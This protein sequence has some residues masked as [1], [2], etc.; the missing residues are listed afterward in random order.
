M[1]AA[2]KL[3]DTSLIITHELFYGASQALRDYL[4]TN[5]IKELF[6]IS[7]P[8]RSENR[9]SY[10][11]SYRSG[12]KYASQQFRRRRAG[13]VVSYIID[14]ILSLYW[15]IFFIRKCDIAVCVDPLSCVS[16]IILRLFKK[17]DTVIFYSIDY[18][19]KRFSHSFL[20]YIYHQIEAFAI[21]QSDECWDVS[22]R[23][24]TG[25]KEFSNMPSYNY[26]KHIV[27]IGVWRNE[28]VRV[29]SLRKYNTHQIIFT[30]TLLKK[31]GIDILLEA[32]LKVQKT[33]PDVSLVIIG[34]GEYAKDIEAKIAYLGLANAVMLL[35]WMSD[36]EKIRS[37]IQNSALAAAL[38]DPKGRSE[39]NFTYFSDPTKI[40]T[41]AACGVPI[42]MTDV[43]HNARALVQSGCAIVVPYESDRLAKAL[44]SLLSHSDRMLQM[45][46]NALTYIQQ[47]TWENIYN[48]VFS[49]KRNK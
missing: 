35:G 18:I 27:P 42:V 23:I 22:E 17:A 8:I 19:P 40:K 34:G 45:R 21:C 12:K 36:Q 16:G 15:G 31:Q 39:D 38:Y 44:V 46:K 14:T 48:T 3:P 20:N 5:K 29:E 2:L 9:T 13:S 26:K 1:Q 49:K 10:F 11:Q 28:I 41:Y 6:I 33:I 30:G 47:Y 37:Y 24:E 25:R 43:P 7:N 32:T 4:I